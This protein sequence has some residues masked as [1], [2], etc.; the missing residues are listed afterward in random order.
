VEAQAWTQDRQ[1]GASTGCRADPRA[2]HEQQ[3]TASVQQNTGRTTKPAAVPCLHQTRRRA[4]IHF[5][6]S[7][8]HVA[9]VKIEPSRPWPQ[10]ATPHVVAAVPHRPSLW[11]ACPTAQH[12][13]PVPKQTK[14][15]PRVD[16]IDQ[17]AHT[18][19]WAGGQTQSQGAPVWRRRGACR[20]WLTCDSWRRGLRLT[21]SR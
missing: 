11:K 13:F 8:L 9:A 16:E 17:G 10:V 12:G 4:R 1:A 14:E 18:A 2:I 6:R 21:C 7:R 5:I 19:A 15:Q 3:P 20:T